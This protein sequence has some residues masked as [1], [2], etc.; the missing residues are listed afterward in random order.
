MSEEQS[1]PLRVIG[2]FEL[3]AKIGQGGMGTVFK[4][5]Q[6]SLDRLV[7]VKILPP[8]AAKD[9][10]FIAR[11]Q[12]EARATA[13]L[14][15][16][17]I[18]KGID[19]GED[20]G[21]WYFAMEYVDGPSLKQLLREQKTIPEEKALEIAEQMAR[22]LECAQA[23]GFVHR[24]IKPDNILL[25][26]RGVAKLA[27]LGLAKQA[28]DD[29][30][31]A[32]AGQ[33]V[34]TPYYMAPEQARGAVDEI[35][36]R[37]DIYALGATL[38]HLVTGRPPFSGPSS[39]SILLKHLTEKAPLAHLIAPAGCG[40]AFSR[41]IER[42]MQKE[43]DKRV[44]SPAELVAQI[45][46]LIKMRAQDRQAQ[47]AKAPP[48]VPASAASIVPRTR[49]SQV[50]S[51]LA[52]LLFMGIL[53]AAL[54]WIYQQSK[55]AA[56]PPLDKL[57]ARLAP[58]Q[59]K[60][61]LVPS[62]GLHTQ[63]PPGRTA[64]PAP[65]DKQ[66]APPTQPKDRPL[67]PPLFTVGPAA[68]ERGPA[69]PGP[70]A[71]KA[72]APPA[73]VAAKT[74]TAARV[75]G[76]NG[77]P[78]GKTPDS[79]APEALPSQAPGPD[80]LV[81][82]AHAQFLGEM[83]Q[84][85]VKEH[86]DLA[87]VLSEM[88]ELA[89]KPEFT[90]AKEQVSGELK[91]L[92]RASRFEER[93]VESLAA[94]KGE[95]E[96]PED[97]LRLAE[98]AKTGKIIGRG[99]SDRELSV[100]IGGATT[101]VSVAKLP[102]RQV[103]ETGGAKADAFAAVIYYLLRGSNN[104]AKAMLPGLSDEDRARTEHKLEVLQTGKAEAAALEAYKQIL[105]AIRQKQWLLA[106]EKILSFEPAHGQTDV[107]MG[108][109]PTLRA[110]KEFIEQSFVQP[111]LK[112]FHAKT[113]KLLPNGCLQLSYDFSAQD[114][115]LDFACE[116]GAL[117]L[118]KGYLK[119][120]FGGGELSQA[121]FV[122]PVAEI[123]AIEVTGK[124]LNTIEDE[125]PRFGL[126]I[127][128]PGAPGDIQAPKCVCRLKTRK[129]HLES[130]EPPYLYG[131]CN[132]IGPKEVNWAMDTTF[133]ADWSDGL[134]KW[135]VNS[136]GIGQVKL[137]AGAIGGRVA[138]DGTNGNHVWKNFKIVFKPDPAWLKEQL[139]NPKADSPPPPPRRAPPPPPPPPPP[140]KKAQ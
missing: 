24:D 45:D 87:K 29:A 136:V 8:S 70:S 11:F 116:H 93:A 140:P 49:G 4:A 39:S 73:D 31:L 86:K 30:A 50:S 124:T 78:A 71:K 2:G 59:K 81:L 88:R 72:D 111:V 66:A 139:E 80:P 94:A 68:V 76:D 38:F 123:Q 134:L 95:L 105:A 117:A 79:T 120:P 43:R 41:L 118:L 75:A 20:G 14:N 61:G 37:T 82:I 32:Q 42:M 114:Q 131:K 97:L 52:A 133:R 35:D 89:E 84:R 98:G 18:V 121:C 135:S 9:A 128:P 129:P 16:P 125:T 130:W 67:L 56:P 65:A 137:P 48:R 115:L 122:P 34:G 74:D 103:V 3:I 51:P 17:N 104:E 1:K 54:W 53:G 119:V 83:L 90:V 102:A 106:R 63:R 101:P 47:Q 110:Y 15:H 27:D 126:Y 6:L 99:L 64:P 55:P 58:E 23:N 12:K 108:K 25:T 132:A 28:D 77:N 21:L 13:Q 62:P 57:A 10:K 109:L 36:M 40:E 33:A 44:Q 96:L 5:R 60:T 138:F 22:A 91:D 46:K 19:V 100:R 7:A 112:L 85:S 127:M 69:A 92:E 26:A 107:G 113:G